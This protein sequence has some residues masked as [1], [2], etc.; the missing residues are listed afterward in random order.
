MVNM[1]ALFDISPEI[2]LDGKPILPDLEFEDGLVR[3]EDF[4]I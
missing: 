1:L 3:F 4:D 2:G